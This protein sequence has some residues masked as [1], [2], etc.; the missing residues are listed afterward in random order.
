MLAQRLDVGI[1][2][3]L[4]CIGINLFSMARIGGNRY[5]TVND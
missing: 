4:G 3:D 2:F 1:E 5:F